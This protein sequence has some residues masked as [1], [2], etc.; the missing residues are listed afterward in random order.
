MVMTKISATLMGGLGNQL[1][2]IFT[3]IACA[4]QNGMEFTFPDSEELTIGITRKTYW[5]NLL[6][7]MGPFLSSPLTIKGLTYSEPCYEFT[8]IP[9]F[10]SDTIL[11]GYFQ[12]YAYFEEELIVIMELLSMQT[13]IR[14]MK[15]RFSDLYKEPIFSMHFRIGDYKQIQDCHPVLPYEYYQKSLEASKATKIL[16]FNE[17]QDEIECQEIINRLKGDFPNVTFTHA[18]AGTEDWEQMLLISCCNG[19]IIANST[20]SWW[21]AV[22]SGV[23]SNVEVF[24][25]VNWFGPTLSKDHNIK[26]LVMY[27][28]RGT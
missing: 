18:P 8:Q 9:K 23:M 21:G 28:W 16:Y 25:P 20:F 13:Q 3:V 10:S 26:D 15:T 1:F 11:K 2:Q 24:Y 17:E 6:K 12:S 7:E 19:H 27:H 14:D 5:K 22:L 4:M